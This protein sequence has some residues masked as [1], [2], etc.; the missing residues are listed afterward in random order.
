MM[1]TIFI[2]REPGNHHQID[3]RPLDILPDTGEFVSLDGET[4]YIVHSIHH[5]L[6]GMLIYIHLDPL[7]DK[8]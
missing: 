2:L 3:N 8:R 5:D 1:D 7:G 4:Y 6:F